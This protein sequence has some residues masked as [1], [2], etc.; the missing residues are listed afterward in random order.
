MPLVAAASKA[1]H[2]LYSSQFCPFIYQSVRYEIVTLHYFDE[3]L[4]KLWIHKSDQMGFAHQK[5]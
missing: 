1:F 3:R 4:K 5:A 2:F